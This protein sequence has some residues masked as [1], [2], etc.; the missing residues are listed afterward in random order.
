MPEIG[1]LGI[2]RA[3]LAGWRV[4]RQIIEPAISREHEI[5]REIAV[6]R[7]HHDEG[8]AAVGAGRRRRDLPP[9]GVAADL[10]EHDLAGLE[11]DHARPEHRTGER[12]LG[13][14][15]GEGDEVPLDDR[16]CGA[17]F[18]VCPRGEGDRVAAHGDAVGRRGWRLAGQT[19][20][21][22][23]RADEHRETRAGSAAT[24]DVHHRIPPRS[25]DSAPVVSAISVQVSE[26]ILSPSG[27]SS[28]ASAVAGGARCTVA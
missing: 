10:G 26:A 19:R 3:G 7:L 21:G 15:V 23:G 25:D 14:A 28:T 4:E 2:G 5:G 6:P 20:G 1:L 17:A 24:T 11:L 8:G 12:G 22:H 13:V 9:L 16:A 27:L 18:P